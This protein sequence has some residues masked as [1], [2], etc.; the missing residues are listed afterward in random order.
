[1]GRWIP[2]SRPPKRSGHYAVNVPTFDL[3]YGTVV[4]CY[5]TGN[6]WVE[7]A[8]SITHWQPLPKPQKARR[9]K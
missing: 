8:D 4:S 3:S 1:M 2:A 5:W 6:E 7:W 9:R